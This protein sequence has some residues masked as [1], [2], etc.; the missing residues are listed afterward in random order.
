MKGQIEDF[1]ASYIYDNC[2]SLGSV[3]SWLDKYYKWPKQP[4]KRV[5]LYKKFNEQ[6]RFIPKLNIE[7][8]D[9]Y[10]NTKIMKEVV[11]KNIR[12]ENDFDNYL[13]LVQFFIEDWGGVTQKT[14]KKDDSY[15]YYHNLVTSR[16]D[17][18]DKNDR[19][20]LA[21]RSSGKSYEVNRYKF[22]DISKNKFG[23]VSS[24]SKYLSVAYPDWAHIY[25]ARVA[26]SINAIIYLNNAFDSKLWPIPA[27]V[28]S[29]MGLI[30]IET[31]II[32]SQTE[33]RGIKSII[34]KLESGGNF[35][36]KF[37][38]YLYIDKD[39]VYLE[40]LNLLAGVKNTLK[41]E[42]KFDGTE[43]DVEAFLFMAADLNLFNDVL[44]KATGVVNK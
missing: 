23:S 4:G 5:N 18:T 14:K 15:K 44:S 7:D 26:Y 39:E 42:Y 38:R 37:R 20:Y 24:W 21:H 1:I 6:A 9:C 41:D 19:Y 34:D 32:V 28:N 27:G 17:M 22:N 10:K 33:G 30:D 16:L 12:G 29:R 40:F 36:S 3:E 31:L 13:R 11:S 8:K 43:G 25:D 2:K 35:A